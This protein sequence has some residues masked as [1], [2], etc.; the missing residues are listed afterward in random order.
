MFLLE[1]RMEKEKII[2]TLPLLIVNMKKMN[3]LVKH[4]LWK[5]FHEN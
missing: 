2:L 1:F 4:M 3:I 5:K